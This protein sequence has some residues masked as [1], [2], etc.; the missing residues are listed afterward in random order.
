[1]F[2]LSTHLQYSYHVFC[3]VHQEL[4][5]IAELKM[6]NHVTMQSSRFSDISPVSDDS[7]FVI[8]LDPDQ[9]NRSSSKSDS[10]EY[11]PFYEVNHF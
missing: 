4:L 7:P 3:V 9:N 11:R 8:K 5:L 2:A 6:I 10:R 1:M